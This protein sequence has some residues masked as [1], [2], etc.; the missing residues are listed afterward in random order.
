MLLSPDL[1]V[2][3][4]L[5]NGVFEHEGER[6]ID[7]NHRAHNDGFLRRLAGKGIYQALKYV[8]MPGRLHDAESWN[9]R[10]YIPIS[11]AYEFAVDDVVSC[12]PLSAGACTSR[13]FRLSCSL[14]LNPA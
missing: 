1:I 10:E 12:S 14:S 11:E 13:D 4:L 3:H 2:E 7:H 8:P 9:T 5:N 6:Y